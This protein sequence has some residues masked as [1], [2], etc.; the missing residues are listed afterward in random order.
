MPATYGGIFIL[1]TRLAAKSGIVG[2]Y[3][4]MMLA[5]AQVL[6]F[7]LDTIENIHIW[8][9]IRK[10]GKK[11]T[12][13]TYKWMRNLEYVKWSF[14]LLGGIGGLSAVAWAWLPGNYDAAS[15]PYIWI[16]FG[17]I[18]LFLIAGFMSKKKE[19]VPVITEPSL[20]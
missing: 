17:E 8:R 7:I 16:F 1:C 18:V 4:F 3:F 20:N 5:L 9:I 11:E 13:A 12:E 15:L 19:E 14:A 6:C 10:D 2:Y